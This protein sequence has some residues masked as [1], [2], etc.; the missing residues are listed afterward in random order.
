MPADKPFTLKKRV[1]RQRGFPVMA[2]LTNVRAWYSP[3]ALSG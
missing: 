2:D 3:E 1:Q